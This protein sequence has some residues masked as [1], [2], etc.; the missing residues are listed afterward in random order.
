MSQKTILVVGG[1]IAGCTLAITLEKMNM[2][3]WLADPELKNS[4]SLSAAGIFN[5]LT[6]KR[7]VKTWLAEDLFPVMKSF[8]RSIE[9]QFL[10]KIL[11]EIPVYRIFPN[12]NEKVNWLQKSNENEAYI[13]TEL[14]KQD[15]PETLL[16]PHGGIVIKQSGWVD[17][18]LFLETV[19][20]YFKSK[21]QFISATILESELEFQPEKI[22]WKDQVFDEVI[23]CTGKDA[24]TSEIFS[25]LP[26]KLTKGEW[27]TVKLPDTY[28]PYI[29]NKGNFAIPFF[30]DHYRVGATYDWDDLTIHPTEK[31]KHQLVIK[32][33]QMITVSPEIMSQHAGIRPTVADRRPLIGRS[34]MHPHLWIFNGLGT[35][36]VTL[37]PYFSKQLAEHIIYGHQL[38]PEVRLNR[39]IPQNEKQLNL[40]E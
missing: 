36:G 24:K 2:N 30:E 27:L 10:R 19:V 17:I 8:Y 25:D 6:G 4:S 38:H 32:L 14:Q 37:A 28:S 13:S 34:R 22:Q 39:H 35:K 7:L 40:S 5:P 1:G 15:L 29:L 9:G 21:K 26:F 31:G 12:E 18:P 3:V 16:H 23:F 11:H 33:A 20:T